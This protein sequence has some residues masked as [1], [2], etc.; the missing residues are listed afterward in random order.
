[1]AGILCLI[2]RKSPRL[3]QGHVRSQ[4]RSSSQ[5][6]LFPAAIHSTLGGHF[7]FSY[8]FFPLP[9]AQKN[10]NTMTMSGEFYLSLTGPVVSLSPTPPHSPTHTHTHTHTHART[11]ARTHTHKH[12]H[13]LPALKTNTF[14]SYCIGETKKPPIA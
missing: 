2:F 1:M 14:M 6:A 4:H 12:T 3:L 5:A 13:T 10:C 11:H 8:A 9:L 7:T